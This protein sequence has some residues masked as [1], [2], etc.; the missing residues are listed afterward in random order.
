MHHN[1]AVAIFFYIIFWY[2]RFSC[3]LHSQVHIPFATCALAA[4]S[5]FFLLIVFVSSYINFAGFPIVLV[6]LDLY[7]ARFQTVL[8]STDIYFAPFPTMLV[9]SDLFSDLLN[10][11]KTT[12]NDH[13][14]RF[15]RFRVLGLRIRWII[16]AIFFK[17]V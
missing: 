11:S 17:V 15:W 1:K 12:I 16:M 3:S 6:S 9:S 10:A 5:F 2:L 8:V 13:S 4:I 7:F 14:N